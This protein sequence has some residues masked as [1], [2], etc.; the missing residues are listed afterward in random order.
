MTYYYDNIMCKNYDNIVCK[1]INISFQD[2]LSQDVSSQAFYRKYGYCR[3]CELKLCVCNQLYC[4]TKTSYDPRQQIVKIFRKHNLDYDIFPSIST[5]FSS[6]NEVRFSMQQKKERSINFSV[7]VKSILL[8]LKR[9]EDAKKN[10][11]LKSK[12]HSTE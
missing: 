3:N 7:I 12:I 2:V 6:L 9:Y 8:F 4:K 1:Q 5:V 10:T 11:R